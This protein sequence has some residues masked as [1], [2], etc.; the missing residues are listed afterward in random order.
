MANTAITP[1]SELTHTFNG[2]GTSGSHI[3]IKAA[4]GADHGTA[5][6]WSSSMGVDLNP[7]I[8]WSNNYIP[9]QGYQGYIWRVCS[10]YIDFDGKVGTTDTVNTYGFLLKSQG[11]IL[12][13]RIYPSDCS[14]AISNVTF[15]KVEMN[16]VEAN[17]T[18]CHTGS[19]ASPQSGS[20]GI[21]Y[22]SSTGTLTVTKLSITNSFLHD[23]GGMIS[24]TGGASGITVANSWLETNFLLRCR[25][26]GV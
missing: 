24:A 2:N 4:T 7:A 15:N 9:S 20:N 14:A 16:G 21:A 19:C 10:S 26:Y 1:C 13:T 6:G 11:F 12:F 23:M 5:T 17:S 22:G 3:T 8:T 25:P 18:N